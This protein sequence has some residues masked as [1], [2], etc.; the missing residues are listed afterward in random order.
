MWK[1]FLS[2]G[3]KTSITS[4]LIGCNRQN[5]VSDTF[6]TLVELN[7]INV[8]KQ[9]IKLLYKQYQYFLPIINAAFASLLK[10]NTWDNFYVYD[11]LREDVIISERHRVIK[12][13]SLYLFKLSV[14]NQEI[15][16]A[17]HVKSRFLIQ[18]L[19]QD[20]LFMNNNCVRELELGNKIENHPPTYIWR[21]F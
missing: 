20:L 18:L 12:M 2:V 16:L 8:Y 15:K 19:K 10:T 7:T 11:W 3:A 17:L 5:I 14:C 1:W 6:L 21:L 13:D 4:P 9:N